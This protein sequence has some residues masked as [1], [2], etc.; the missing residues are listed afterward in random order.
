MKTVKINNDSNCANCAWSTEASGRDAV[1][2]LNPPVYIGGDAS[3]QGSWEQPVV[4]IH[5]I[6]SQW[7]QGDEVWE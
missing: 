2:I 3:V 4:S 5:S 7:K 6:C 1:C